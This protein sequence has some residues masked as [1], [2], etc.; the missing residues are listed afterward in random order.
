MEPNTPVKMPSQMLGWNAGNNSD[1]PLAQTPRG[2]RFGAIDKQPSQRPR[3]ATSLAET[4]KQ[5]PSLPGFHNSFFDTPSKYASQRVVDKGKGKQ[6]AGF[7]NDNPF[8]TGNPRSSPPSSPLA[9]PEPF[10][11]DAMDLGPVGPSNMSSPPRPTQRTEDPNDVDMDLRDDTEMQDEVE[12]YDP[13]NWRDEVKIL[14]SCFC[15]YITYFCT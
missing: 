3:Q 11:D 9:Q 8:F 4:S 13:P 1:F 14:G 10:Q 12:D 5:K 6:R 7:V 2:P 15:L